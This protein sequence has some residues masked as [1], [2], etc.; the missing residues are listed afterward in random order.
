LIYLQQFEGFW[1]LTRA[2]FEALAAHHLSG[3]AWSLN[4]FGRRLVGP[5]RCARKEEHTYY[6]ASNDHTVLNM[7]CDWSDEEW[8]DHLAS[9]QETQP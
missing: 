5:P 4:D 1:S 6:S 3:K 2:Q 9:I 8:R 7:P